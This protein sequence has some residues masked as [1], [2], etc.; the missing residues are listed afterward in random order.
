MDKRDYLRRLIYKLNI[1]Y[2]R[3]CEILNGIRSIANDSDSSVLVAK[4][5]ETFNDLE[6]KE[7]LKLYLT[8]NDEYSIKLNQ[9]A[10]IVRDVLNSDILFVSQTN[11]FPEEQVLWDRIQTQKQTI[12]EL[13]G[14]F[15]IINK[16]ISD[17]THIQSV[18]S[19]IDNLNSTQLKEQI[20]YYQKEQIH[21]L[22]TI[23][24]IASIPDFPPIEFTPILIRS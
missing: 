15:E 21:I 20:T 7:M 19:D 11:P 24:D 17:Y 3:L 13:I 14:S 22:K 12:H 9:I 10:Q 5:L 8:R 23:V 6:L 2:N 1:E 16:I 18:I 4:Y